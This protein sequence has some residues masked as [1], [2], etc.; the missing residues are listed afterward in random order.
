MTLFP[1]F[2]DIEDK[3]FLVVGS[4]NVAASKVKR[5]KNFTN[6]ITVLA[7]SANLEGVKLLNKSFEESDIDGFDF[8]IA[9]TDDKKLNSRISELC[10]ERNILVNSVDD[11]DNC[12]FIFPSLIKRGDLTIGI[13]TGGKAPSVSKC[14]RK[15]IEKTLPDDIDELINELYKLRCELK[16]T[17]SDIKKRSA[18]LKAEA[19]KYF[20]K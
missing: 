5:L 6:N 4:G 11:P 17:E 7:P 2:V 9:A 19:E 1:F 3:K 14:V 16:E 20:N 8:V 12:S 15:E 10:L 18:L 13:C